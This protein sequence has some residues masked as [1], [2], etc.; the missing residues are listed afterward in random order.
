MQLYKNFT[1]SVSVII[2]TFNRDK[3]L[4][5]ALDS[6]LSQ[7]FQDWEC[8]IVDDGSS[9]NTFE[10]VNYYLEKDS[11]FRYMKHTNKKPPLT[12]NTG[13]QASIGRFITFLGSDDEYKPEHLQL[14]YDYM[15]N[16]TEVDLIQGGVEVVGH[17]F[18]KDM[19]DLTKEIHI[20]E[21]KVGGTFLGKREVFFELGGFRNLEYADD[22]DFWNRA[23]EN[24]K[25][26]SV[27]W[28]TYIYYRDTPDSICTNI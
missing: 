27:N 6:V 2:A 24:F 26:A 11:R 28:Q 17:P 5:R 15:I 21:C 22:A 16:N 19:N 23:E 1:P 8:I 13:I 3:L 4:P 20:S 7:T 25:T 9:D 18:V 10:A 14:R 12:F